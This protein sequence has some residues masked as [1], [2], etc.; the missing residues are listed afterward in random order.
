M[1][2]DRHARKPHRLKEASNCNAVIP[3][4]DFHV[5]NF[6]KLSHRFDLYIIVF[7]VISLFFSLNSLLRT[8]VL[9]FFCFP[10]W[11]HVRTKKK[12]KKWG[13]LNPFNL[14]ADVTWLPTS[15]GPVNC[16]EGE[17]IYLWLV[18][19]LVYV[20]LFNTPFAEWTLTLALCPIHHQKTLLWL[21]SN[22]Q[23]VKITLKKA[24]ELEWI[25]TKP[26]WSNT[27]AS[28]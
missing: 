3:L 28:K 9:F 1:S 23:I 18:S 22:L 21:I 8:F 15:K 26:P 10:M 14:K 16:T 20:N 13:S 2:P 25:T 11:I 5:S 6:R 24:R 7:I 19:S 27:D 17:I 12:E 4:S